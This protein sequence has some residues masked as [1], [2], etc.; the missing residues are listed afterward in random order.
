MLVIVLFEA[1]N[2]TLAGMSGDRC[3]IDP[4]WIFGVSLQPRARMLPCGFTS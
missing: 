3:R 2:V 1:R 4:S